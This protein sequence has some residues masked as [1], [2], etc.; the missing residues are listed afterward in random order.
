MAE[1][2]CPL[3]G[4]DRVMH[5]ASR[6]RWSLPGNR[7]GRHNAAELVHGSIM[8]R[9]KPVIALARMRAADRTR[10]LWLDGPGKYSGRLAWPRQG[11][12]TSMP[13][14]A[15]ASSRTRARRADIGA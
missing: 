11:F 15:I 3:A 5:I 14:R 7:F 13:P 8:N 2:A 1:P 6:S 4:P 12:L 10:N 9:F